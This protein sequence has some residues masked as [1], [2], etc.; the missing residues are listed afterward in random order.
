MTQTETPINE[1]LIR[2]A[3]YFN[4]G[5]FEKAHFVC[6]HHMQKNPSD[7]D[8]LHLLAL[9]AVKRNKLEESIT[10][11]KKACWLRPDDFE[12]LT[13][14][15][16]LMKANGSF[17][18]AKQY[19][20]QAIE[21]RPDG[22]VALNNLALLFAEAGKFD[23]AIPVYK[24]AIALND[25]VAE[26]Y[27]SLSIVYRAKGDH[28]R[29]IESCR[30]A[31]AIKP[32]FFEGRI[33]LANIYFENN[34]T[35]ESL[36]NFELANLIQPDS[37]IALN[38]IGVCHTALGN[39]IEAKNILLKAIAMTPSLADAQNN[40]A[41]VHFILGEYD[42]AAICAKAALKLKP[43]YPEALRNYGN[44]MA[45]QNQYTA[46]IDFYKKAL[47]IQPDFYEAYL[48]L[49]AAYKNSAETSHAK[50]SLDMAVK[51]NSDSLLPV[52][53]RIGASL[54]SF[55]NSFE[56]I[57]ICRSEYVAGLE[58]LKH[59]LKNKSQMPEIEEALSLAQPTYL[60]YQGL[61]DLEV[62]KKYSKL[63]ET[64]MASKYPLWSK[65]KIK[66]EWK[67]GQ[68]IR[69]GI[70]SHNFNNHVDWK[71]ITSGLVNRIDRD[72]FDIHAY[73]TG[74]LTDE[75]TQLVSEKANTFYRSSET[76]RLADQ[77]SKDNI[78]ILLFPELG[79]DPIS[80]RV[81]SLRLAPIQ[82]CAWGRADTSGLSTVDY[83]LSPQIMEP[84]DAQLNYQEKLVL[85]PDTGF[86][87][88]EQNI[89][90]LS[91]E[92]LPL[93][94]DKTRFLCAQSLFKIFASI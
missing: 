77:I 58:Q 37:A 55:Y 40:L 66:H 54:P 31:L 25:N 28:D 81:A 6:Q 65:A 42:Y 49:A 84:N 7:A 69:L 33:H 24:K 93:S 38:G 56:E 29:A 78:D 41:S 30:Q 52:C 75:I 85:I 72:N 11:L 34:N 89:P 90:Q 91:I 92:S 26:L 47:H 70:V 15:G 35:V 32:Q 94:L 8:A 48:E 67:R 20:E 80:L 64:V 71:I 82:C 79:I 2:A 50:S 45:A 86:Y 23:E 5:D 13:N 1:S 36:A 76:M 17:E 83:Y 9:I 43:E 21:I 14:L 68:K 63:L 57:G 62:H 19:Y 53:G 74:G 46:A 12:F 39:Y 51:I 73:S 44:I 60:S 22:L 10:L 16:N 88:E 87:Y 18:E 61:H 3:K 59:R 27:F 4:E